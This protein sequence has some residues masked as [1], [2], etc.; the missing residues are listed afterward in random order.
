[1]DPPIDLSYDTNIIVYY[2]FSFD[3]SVHGKKVPL[4]VEP[5][6]DKAQAYTKEKIDEEQRLGT[7]S[8]VWDELSDEAA[9]FI[10]YRLFENEEIQARIEA[11]KIPVS[12]L[13]KSYLSERF[14]AKIKKLS[15]KEWFNVIPFDF[16]EEDKRKL[17][18]AYLNL[19]NT[20]KMQEH[21]K[22]KDVDSPVP[23]GADIP[24]ILFSCEH[25]VPVLTND[26]DLTEFREEL[27]QAGFNFQV[28][29]FSEV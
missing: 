9:D 14:K 8:Q 19:Q 15:N 22:K 29:A 17:E 23:R 10:F 4:K 5:C 20:P 2:C 24:L 7:I 6:T 3:I 1:M 12:I 27:A 13:L 28:I 21:M 11:E 26:S 18:Q 16:R 25:S